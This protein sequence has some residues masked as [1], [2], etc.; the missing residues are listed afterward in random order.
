MNIELDQ[1]IGLTVSDEALE[2]AGEPLGLKFSI[3]PTAPGL[4]R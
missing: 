1:V 3:F 4:C 2:A